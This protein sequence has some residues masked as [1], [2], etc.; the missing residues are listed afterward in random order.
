MAAHAEGPLKFQYEDIDQQNDT[1]VIG[2]WSFMVTEIMF[3]GGLFLIYTLYRSNYQ[4]DWWKAHTGLSIEL[5]GINTLNLLISSLLMA[6]AVRAA[7]KHDRTSVLR[8]L[9]GVL[10]CGAIFMGIKAVEYTGKFS[11]NLYP[12]PSFTQDPVA[13]HG[14]NLDHAQLFYGLY[15]G[16]T[17]LH[18]V[19][20]VVGML[21]IS[22]LM[23]KW[24]RRHKVVTEDYIPTELIGLYWHFVD[25][26]W[27]FLYPLFYLMPKPYN[28]I[29]GGGH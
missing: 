28:V 9:T 14:A 13:V 25:I 23:Y 19:H 10:T 1:Y 16:M 7:Q 4:G 6:L 3:F 17:G 5:G 27:I 20:V 21:I 29:G 8:L 12:G 24:Y 2:M 26:V 15:F 11:H 18:G 22:V